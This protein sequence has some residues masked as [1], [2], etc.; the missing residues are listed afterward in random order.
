[1]KTVCVVCGGRSHEHEISLLSAQ[2][3]LC[4]IDRE[5]Y[6]VHTLI[7]DEDGSIFHTRQSGRLACGEWK[8]FSDLTP[9]L[10]PTDPKYGGILIFKDGGFECIPVDVFFPVLH[11]ENGEDGTI[12]GVFEMSGVPYVGSGVLSSASC[13]DKEVTHIR[14][15]S[16]NIRTARYI[17]AKIGCDL[18]ALN[19]KIEKSFGYPVFVKPANAGS[20]VGVSRAECKNCLIGALEKAFEVDSKVLIE[21]CLVGAEVECAVLGNDAAVAADFVGQ[22]VPV[23]G[24]YDFDAKYTSGTTEL[25]IP[26]KIEDKIAERI[27]KEA[28]K[29]YKCMDCRSLSRIDFFVLNDGEIVLNEINNL[30]GF[31]Q[32]SMYPKLFEASGICYSRLIDR[33]I[34]SAFNK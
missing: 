6:A 24:F 7:I 28:V 2:S 3:V 4:N 30:P 5:K 15:D 20:S 19:E 25:L 33:I 16:Q 29:A 23:D 18:K 21:E 22:V 34:E 27:R 12:Q 11:G 1:M 8:S 31:T 9:A 17:T 10:I 26:A 32:I 14:L 13:M